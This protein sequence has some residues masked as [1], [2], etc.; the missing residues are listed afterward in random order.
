M[1]SSDLLPHDD[2]KAVMK[3]SGLRLGVQEMTHWGMKESEMEEIARFFKESLID[4]KSVKEAVNQFRSRFIEVKYSF[5]AAGGKED[6]PT[7]KLG[8]R[9]GAIEPDLAGY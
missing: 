5:D 9:P 4:G 7:K 1:C 3:P 6:A 2:P 8:K